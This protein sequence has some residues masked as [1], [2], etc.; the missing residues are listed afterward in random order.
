MTVQSPVALSEALVGLSAHLRGLGLH[1]ELPGVADARR[2]RDELIAQIEDY[3]LPRLR[4][5]DAPLLAVVGGS[6]GAGKST[7]VN[8]LVGA[9]VS[10]AGVLR[11]TTRRPAIVCNPSD[12]RWFTDD[13]I[14]PQ[15][16]RSSG[17][18]GLRLV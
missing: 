15:L 7:L 2:V 1:L 4:S 17:P 14:L 10:P 18:D 16:P 9:D 11:P 12:L 6:T 8:S 3:L 13:R 5:I